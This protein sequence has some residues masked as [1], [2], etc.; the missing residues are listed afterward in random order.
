L[1]RIEGVEDIGIFIGGGLG[2]LVS[3]VKVAGNSDM[4]GNGKVVIVMSRA[5]NIPHHIHRAVKAL[6]ELA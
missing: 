1:L 3:C 5:V 2:G 6:K 4:L